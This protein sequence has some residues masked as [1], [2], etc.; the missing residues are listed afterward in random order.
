MRWIALDSVGL[1]WNAL[2]CFGLRWYSL[3]CVGFLSIE[4]DYIV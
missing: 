2:D 4:L 3:G 1:H